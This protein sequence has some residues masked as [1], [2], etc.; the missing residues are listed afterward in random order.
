M[1]KEKKEDT[2]VPSRQTFAQGI[3]KMLRLP[4]VQ[5]KSKPYAV[6]ASLIF[7][8]T[9]YEPNG[10]GESENQMRPLLTSDIPN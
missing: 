6:L 8:A 9:W 7:S 5:S 4:H 10:R 3:S 1:P 2:N